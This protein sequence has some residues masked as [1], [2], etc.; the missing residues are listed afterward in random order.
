MST[1]FESINFFTWETTFDATV[2]L[3]D[4]VFP[5]KYNIN[6]AFLPKTEEIELQNI[7]FDRVKFL[8]ENLCENSVVFNPK[9]S[10]ATMWYKMP[11]N[12]ILLPGVPY[13]QLMATALYR[14]ITSISG[15][16]FHFGFISI[17]SKLGDNVKY[18]IDDDSFEHKH[19]DVDNWVSK[20]VPAPWWTREDT[21][22]FDQSFGG[23]EFWTGAE[24]WKELGFDETNT[25]TKKFN[26]TIVDGGKN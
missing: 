16:Y 15:N 22:T 8:L 23:K 24:S 18:V 20:N 5:N 10:T 13:D 21:A 4:C 17:D 6:I 1:E 11:I 7:G 12:K 9:D 26:P 2:V 3:D 19:L 25:K 14:K